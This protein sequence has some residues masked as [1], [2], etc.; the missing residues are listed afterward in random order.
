MRMQY[1]VNTVLANLPDRAAWGTENDDQKMNDAFKF[2]HFV[3]KCSDNV[4]D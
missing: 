2:R 1:S 3:V 4:I